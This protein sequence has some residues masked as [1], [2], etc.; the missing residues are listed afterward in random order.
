MYLN[1]AISNTDVR[2]ARWLKEVFGGAIYAGKRLKTQWAPCYHW[3][4]TSRRAADVITGC[5]PFFIIK[6]EQADVA[7]AF[8]ST[9]AADRRY[10]RKGRPAELLERQAALSAQLSALKGTS[11]R[12]PRGRNSQTIQ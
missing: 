7:L 5:A 8:Q 6:R 4:V 2:L 12:V 1:L 10:G 9:I 3:Y 11:S